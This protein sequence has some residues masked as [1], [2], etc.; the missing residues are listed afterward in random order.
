MKAKDALPGSSG[1]PAWSSY[2]VLGLDFPQHLRIFPARCTYK[3]WL[4]TY[5]YYL[6]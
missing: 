1:L 4:S 6:F 2:L 3:L 5:V